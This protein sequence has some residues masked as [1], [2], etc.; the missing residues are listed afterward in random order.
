M[1]ITITCPVCNKTPM[2]LGIDSKCRIIEEAVEVVAGDD[3]IEV[4]QREIFV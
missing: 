3:Y 2:R 4:P 1:N